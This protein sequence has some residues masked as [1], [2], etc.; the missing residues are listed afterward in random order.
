M[1]EHEGAFEENIHN[2]DYRKK[3]TSKKID[4][5]FIL[6]DNNRKSEKLDG[7][8]NH[9]ADVYDTCLR[10]EWFT[11]PRKD[12]E[13]WTLPWDWDFDQWD[14]INVPSTWNTE[15]EQY[16]LFEGSMV[17]TRTFK[18]DV[19][20]L[21][22]V[23]LKIGAAYHNAMVFLNGTFLG[24]H[25][26]GDTPFYLDVTEHLLEDNRIL[27]SVN[28]TRTPGRIPT[29]FTDCYNYVGLYRTIE[30]SVFPSHL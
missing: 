5:S 6:Y 13:G 3:Y 4:S 19:D 29:I 27:L 23:V 16:K 26:G 24:F 11:E 14:T 15:Q 17:Y 22:K 25:E 18:Y 20:A 7:I 1:S 8:W 9:H 2:R 28:N 12:G 10:Q 21:E 30:L